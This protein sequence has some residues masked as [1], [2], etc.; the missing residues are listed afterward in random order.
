MKLANNLNRFRRLSAMSHAVFRRLDD[1]IKSPADKKEYR[2]LQLNNG[3]KVLLISGIGLS[4]TH[5]LLRVD[6]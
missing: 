2:S 3:L 5:R 6:Y 4:M 1:V